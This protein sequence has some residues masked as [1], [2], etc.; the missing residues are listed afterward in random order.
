MN[1]IKEFINLC[2]GL[3]R[4]EVCVLIACGI[5][6]FICETIEYVREHKH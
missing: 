5:L 6:W 2:G 1:K 4:K 3:N